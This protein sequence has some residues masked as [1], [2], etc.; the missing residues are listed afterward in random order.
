MELC[1]GK[2]VIDRMVDDGHISE[3]VV[4]QIIYKITS[5]LNYC[6]SIGIT[7][8]DIKPENILFESR[9]SDSE[10][11]LIDFGLSKKHNSGEKMHTILG[12][13]YYVAPEVLQGSYDDKCDIWS[14]GAIT[15]FM[16]CGDPPFTG[17]NNSIIF[18]KIIKSEVVFDKSKWENISDKCKEFILMCMV[19]NPEQRVSASKALEH[20]WFKRVEKEIHNKKHVDPE[21]LVKLKTF[22]HPNKFKKLVLKFLVNNIGQSELKKLRAS[23]IAIDTH[24]S[25]FIDYEELEVAFKNAG[26][27]FSNDQLHGIFKNGECN[28]KIDY[29]EFLAASL[30]QKSFL[31]KE[32]L[33]KAFKFFDVN[34]DGEID[35]KDLKKALLKS[36]KSIT[37]TEEFKKMILEINHE[38]EKI[39]LR[40]F[41]NIFGL[42]LEK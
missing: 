8:R 39:S 19:K 22:Q 29:S 9:E 18:D 10:V 36:G 5:A 42:D 15:Y 30:D 41:I 32:K 16:I 34:N 2:E 31:F 4:Q 35:S 14:V 24:N 21:I 37:N 23:F 6:H 27:S 38:R 13:P 26:I 7:H 3:Y 20:P 25:G 17:H 33:I 40:K 28:G 12:T 1:K 11:K